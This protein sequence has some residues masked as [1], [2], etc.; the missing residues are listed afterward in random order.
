MASRNGGQTP[1]IRFQ[2]LPPRR[3]KRFIMVC[4]PPEERGRPVVRHYKSG[5]ISERHTER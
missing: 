4:A 5:L 1:R 2:A 3:T